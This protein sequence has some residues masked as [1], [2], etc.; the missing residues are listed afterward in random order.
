MKKLDIAIIEDELKKL[1]NHSSYN[2]FVQHDDSYRYAEII[3]KY[4][5]Y[6]LYCNIESIETIRAEYSRGQRLRYDHFK[7]QD[8]TKENDLNCY[9]LVP[10]C[11]H[12]NSDYKSDKELEDTILHPLKEDFDSLVK[13]DIDITPEQLGSFSEYKINFEILPNNTESLT[14][15]AEQTIIVFNLERRYNSKNTKNELKGFF[16]N[17]KYTTKFKVNGYKN[18]SETEEDIKK[19]I[20]DVSKCEINKTKYGKLKKDLTNKYLNID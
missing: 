4:A 18:L 10:S 1:L 13:F 20:F 15:K 7:K 12:C 6:C 19:A 11:H 5:S 8:G 3:N 2:A 17:L 16:N 9:N 14:R